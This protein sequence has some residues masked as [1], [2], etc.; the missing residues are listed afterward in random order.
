MRMRGF[1]SV[2]LGLIVAVMAAGAEK[3]N[4]AGPIPEIAL[5]DGRVLRDVQIKAFNRQGVMLRHTEGVAQIPYENFPEPYREAL[6]NARPEPAPATSP[7]RRPPP[8]AAR[9][10]PTARARP[11]QVLVKDVQGAVIVMLSRRPVPLAD[12]EV[13]A[14]PA[15]D[16]VRYDRNRRDSF[17]PDHREL[18]GALQGRN[19]SGRTSPSELAQFRETEYAS[20]DG[21][22]APAAAARTDEAGRFR[23]TLPA[24][25]EHIVFARARH[26]E[27]AT[28][29]VFV[30]AVLVED[31]EII[32]GSHNQFETLR[33]L[34]P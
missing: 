17:T 30:W 28:A 34:E 2:M 7:E 8:P 13:A 18:R 16:F 11:T 3:P 31:A 27:G 25:G 4:L 12:L 32:L 1:F 33:D 10:A 6:L 21:L 14:Y 20:W 23:L 24:D 29:H 26:G 5:L 9:P 22:G 15:E 19:A